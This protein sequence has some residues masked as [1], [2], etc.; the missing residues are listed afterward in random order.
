MRLALVPVDPASETEHD[1]WRHGRQDGKVLRPHPLFRQLDL[2]TSQQISRSFPQQ[3][4]QLCVIHHRRRAGANLELVLSAQHPR[5]RQRLLDLGVDLLLHR[6]IPV[7]DGSRQFNRLW[8]H[9]AGLPSMNRAHGD[10]GRIKGVQAA[11][12]DA[13]QGQD[14]VCGEVDRIQALVRIGPMRTLP[15]DSDPKSIHAGRSGTGLQRDLTDG[16]AGMDVE[17]HDRYYPI[18]HPIFYHAWC[19]AE[20]FLVRHLF[21]RLE[22]KPNRARKYI[23]RQQ[24]CHAQGNR[25]MGIVATAMHHPRAL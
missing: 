24:G 16:Q 13:M 9:I 18:H 3:C 15:G 6:W 11:R 5:H 19:A 21:R 7:A 20:S 23:P 10:H 8:D 14:H 12:D 4:Y 17:R 1:A 25:R 22:E 2:L